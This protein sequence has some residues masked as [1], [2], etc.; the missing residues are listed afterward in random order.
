MHT[1]G[2]RDRCRATYHGKKVTAENWNSGRKTEL[3]SFYFNKYV[4][5]RPDTEMLVS[6]YF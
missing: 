3:V 2:E 6:T 4:D 1:K 5:L